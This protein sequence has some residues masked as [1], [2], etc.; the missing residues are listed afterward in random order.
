M[1]RYLPADGPDSALFTLLSLLCLQLLPFRWGSS[2]NT[3]VHRV[4]NYFFTK[5]WYLPIFYLYL[6]YRYRRV[7][8]YLGWYLPTYCYY[9]NKIPGSYLIHNSSVLPHAVYIPKH[10]LSNI[11]TIFIQKFR[12]N[13]FERF[14]FTRFHSMQWLIRTAVLH[15]KNTEEKPM[16]M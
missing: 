4:Q 9:E 7:P 6:P 8:T 12:W 16:E 15:V 2:C 3:N 5:V 11:S 14:L 1:Y 10:A 13:S